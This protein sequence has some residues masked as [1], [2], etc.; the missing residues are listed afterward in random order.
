MLLQGHDTLYRHRGTGPVNIRRGTP[1]TAEIKCTASSERPESTILMHLPFDELVCARGT[2]HEIAERA[3]LLPAFFG[4]SL[5]VVSHTI[6]ECL[7]GCGEC[8]AL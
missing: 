7:Y 6:A 8:L 4:L 3:A 2:M 5:V 1:R